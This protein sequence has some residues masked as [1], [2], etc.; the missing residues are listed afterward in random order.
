MANTRS[1]QQVA[2][3]LANKRNT[4]RIVSYGQKQYSKSCNNVFVLYVFP[5]DGSINLMLMVQKQQQ[6]FFLTLKSRVT[7]MRTTVEMHT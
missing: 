1:W 2:H 5:D 4:N 6:F 3:N 7:F